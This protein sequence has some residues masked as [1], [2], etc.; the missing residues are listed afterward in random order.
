ML[1]GSYR[2]RD[3]YIPLFTKNYARYKSMQARIDRRMARVLE[4]PYHSTE[5]LG[6]K[7][8]RTN[9]HGCRSA[10]V[11][12]NFRPVF[13]ICEECRTVPECE[14]CFCEGLPDQTVVFLTVEPHERAY[15]LR[16]SEMEYYKSEWKEPVATDAV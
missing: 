13:V 9:L 8:G 10:R 11:D 7:S 2:Y 4:N 12:R 3:G 6:R 5:S 15:A 16:E 14:Y 1:T